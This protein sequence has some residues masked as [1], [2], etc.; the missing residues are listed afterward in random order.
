MTQTTRAYHRL[1]CHPRKGRRRHELRG[2]CK[3]YVHTQEEL[4]IMMPK[5]PKGVKVRM[6]W[7]EE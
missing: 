1:G 7:W 2:V 3:E 5:I 6:R 4:E